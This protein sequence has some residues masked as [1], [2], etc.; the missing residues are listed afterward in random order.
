MIKD[1][2]ANGGHRAK[3]PI[4]WLIVALRSRI[5]DAYVSCDWLYQQ[6]PRWDVSLVALIALKNLI[7]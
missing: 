6:Y 1:W 5:S 3:A 7:S 2:A 4:M